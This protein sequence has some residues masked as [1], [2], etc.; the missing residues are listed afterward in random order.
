ME[1]MSDQGVPHDKT[2]FF[3]TNHT[4]AYG[5]HQIGKSHVVALGNML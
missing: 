3:F 5:D 2:T 4:K 1:F